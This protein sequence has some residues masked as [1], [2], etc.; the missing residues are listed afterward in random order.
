[1][2]TSSESWPPPVDPETNVR[3]EQTTPG[4]LQMS[5][6]QVSLL[7]GVSIVLFSFIRALSGLKSSYLLKVALHLSAS[8]VAGLGIVMG[9]PA[10]IRPFLGAGVD[11]FPFLGLHRRSYYGASWLLFAIGLL[12]VAAI[13]TH[14]YTVPLIV[15]L[16]IL[17]GLGSNLTM[18]VMDSIMVSIGNRTGTIARLQAIQQGIPI[19]LGLTCTGVI[20]GYVSQHWSYQSCYGLAG[21]LALLASATYLLVHEKPVDDRYRKG[22]TEPIEKQIACCRTR[23][24]HYFAGTLDLRYLCV[25]F[26]NHAW[27]KYGAVLLHDEC[28]AFHAYRYWQAGKTR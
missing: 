17:T 7:I 27:R 1:M 9:I 21:L 14:G 15:A 25:L 5:V 8:Q 26:D 6:W 4:N 20:A 23:T 18:V 11:L 24:R 22:L 10:Y 2:S 19:I 3:A 12:T 13:P 16:S 28:P